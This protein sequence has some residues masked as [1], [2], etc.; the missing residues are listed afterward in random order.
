MIFG[1]VIFD[2]S[3]TSC[4]SNIIRVSWFN[5]IISHPFISSLSFVSRIIKRPAFEPMFYQCYYTVFLSSHLCLDYLPHFMKAMKCS[6]PTYKGAAKG[7]VNISIK[8]QVLI[9]PKAEAYLKTHPK[10][11]LMFKHIDDYGIWYIILFFNLYYFLKYCTF[12]G[13]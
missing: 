3:V 7:Q 10:Y 2:L 13:F 4:P 8:F 1:Q 5:A 9:L 6:D 12:Y 11:L